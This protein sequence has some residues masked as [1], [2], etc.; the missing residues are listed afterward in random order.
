M[1]SKKKKKKYKMKQSIPTDGA[2]SKLRGGKGGRTRSCLNCHSQVGL[3]TLLRH[4]HRGGHP[5]SVTILTEDQ[6]AF[7]AAQ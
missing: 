2:S 3:A 1:K 7:P 6:E 5:S 4:R